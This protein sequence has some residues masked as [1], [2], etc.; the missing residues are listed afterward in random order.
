M[1]R[2]VLSLLL[3]IAT[4]G[5]M[6]LLYVGDADAHT[7]QS[8]CSQIHRACNHVSQ[9]DSKVAQAICDD[10]RD[11]CRADCVANAE[12]CPGDCEAA[13]AACV[14][15]CA[16]NPTCEAACAADLAQCLDDCANCRSNCNHDRNLCR[17]A[18][19]AARELAREGCK[20]A[21]DTCWAICEDPIDGACVKVCKADL[22][23]CS[24]AAKNSERECK[25]ACAKGTER[26]PCVRTCRR[27]L[28]EAL[29]LCASGEAL[30]VGGCIGLPAP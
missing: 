10:L 1:K 4:T 5:L 25:K 29:S 23:T 30:C 8:A 19:Q 16:G 12:T 9:A 22:K 7:C 11:A 18:A 27:L 13:D 21:R 3:A 14:A 24:H 20:T 15:A 2:V 26:R 17:E 28:N 6:S